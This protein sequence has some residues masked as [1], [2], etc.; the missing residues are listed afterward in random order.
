MHTAHRGCPGPPFAALNPVVRLAAHLRTL[1]LGAVIALLT[2]PPATALRAEGGGRPARSERIASLLELANARRAK[3]GV[4]GLR[5]DA[6]LMQAAQAQAEQ[7]AAAGRLQHVLPEA[8]YPRPQDRLDAFGYPWQAFAE[9][10]AYG[11][12]DAAATIDAWMKSPGHRK[13]LLSPTYTELGTGYATDAAGRSYDV[14][15]FGRP[16]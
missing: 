4:P 9:N 11:H 15:V 5:A 13:N 16:R 1:A 2:W 7:A 3:E 8:R 12:P 10:I 6:K 14:Q